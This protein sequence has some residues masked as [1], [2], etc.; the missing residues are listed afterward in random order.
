MS[1]G[2]GSRRRIGALVHGIVQG[3]GFRR[4]VER[5]A[6]GLALDGLVMNRAD[7]SVELDAEGPGPA[8]DA[9]VAALHEGPP[10]ASV[11]EV[12]VTELPPIGIA[13]GFAVRSGAHRG[14]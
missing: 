8:I 13:T 10:A 11:A 14:D 2:T 5:T 7:G 3:V 12:R 6:S 4:F 1:G 9:L